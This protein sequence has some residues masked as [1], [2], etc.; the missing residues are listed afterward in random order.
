MT[1]DKNGITNIIKKEEDPSAKAYGKKD[2]KGK[3]QS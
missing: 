2:K 3:K 1:A